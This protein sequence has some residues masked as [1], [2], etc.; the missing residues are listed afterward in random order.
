M[1]DGVTGRAGSKARKKVSGA[2]MLAN[3][4]SGSSVACRE[5]L[6][7]GATDWKQE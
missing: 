2:Q 5:Q 4:K 3:G 7:T 1:A 6:E